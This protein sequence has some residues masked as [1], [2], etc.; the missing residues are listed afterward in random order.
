MRCYHCTKDFDKL[1]GWGNLDLC[2]VC[3]KLYRDHF[4]D[5]PKAE[6]SDLTIDEPRFAGGASYSPRTGKTIFRG[7]NADHAETINHEFMHFVLHE[8]IGIRGCYQYDSIQGTIDPYH[9][10]VQRARIDVK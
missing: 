7:E 8:V 6:F 4:P 3:A 1:E 5:K 2:P 9:G 10:S